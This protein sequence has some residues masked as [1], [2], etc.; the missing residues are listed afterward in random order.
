MRRL[1]LHELLG[2]RGLVLH[3]ARHVPSQPCPYCSEPL[4][5]ASAEHDDAPAPGNVTICSHCAGVCQFGPTM[6]LKRA[7]IEAL[8]AAGY[9]R[10][11]IEEMVAL[12]KKTLVGVAVRGV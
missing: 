10:K 4:N 7:E 9:Q 1:L 12:A 2:T 5:V 8:V 11:D 3:N 6:E